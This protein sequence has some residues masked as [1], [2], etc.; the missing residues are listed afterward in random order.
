MAR[1]DADT[2]RAHLLTDAAAARR[3]ADL[4]TESL[5][6]DDAVTLYEAGPAQWGVEI[7]F[8]RPPDEDAVRALVAGLAGEEA[9]RVLAFETIAPRDWVAAS[10]AGLKP[11][12]AGRFLVHGAHD[13]AAATA[14]RLAIEIEAALAFGTGHHGTTR[15]CLIAL[16]W[17]VKQQRKR[18]VCRPS[19]RPRAS[20]GLHPPPPRRGE[21]ALPS[22][23]SVGGKHKFPV[24]HRSVH[25]IRILDL[26][27]GTGVLAIAAAKALRRR[28]LASDLD[29][30]AVEAACA[31][32]RLNNVGPW[33]VTLRAR[34]VTTPRLQQARFDL[35]FANILL[36]PLKLLAVPLAR[37]LAPNGY[38]VLSGLL[39]AHANAALSAYRDQGFQLVRRVSLDGWVTLLMRRS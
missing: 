15:G 28:V 37:R 17:W 39:A 14:H 3:L 24:C 6:P 31:N 4:L 30:R 16:D 7:N 8:A 36:G 19:V 5:D 13:R 33:I 26:G 2:V 34:G 29:P 25:A 12:A 1:P 22:R 10:L 38:L 9:G 21:G 20:R 23:G 27:A 11:V 18:P 35:V 32:A